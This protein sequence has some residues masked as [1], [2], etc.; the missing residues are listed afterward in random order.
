MTDNPKTLGEAL[1]KLP[2]STAPSLGQRVVLG[3]LNTVNVLL[4]TILTAIPVWWA[5]GDP[6]T[7]AVATTAI[8]VCALWVVTRLQRRKVQN[9]HPKTPQHPLLAHDQQG[10]MKDLE[11]RQKTVIFDGSNLYHFGLAE[12]MGPRV[13]GL[14]ARQLRAEGYRVVCFFDANIHFTLIENGGA[15]TGKRHSIETLQ[16]SFDIGPDEIYVVPSGVQADKFILDSLKHLPISFAVTN[17]RFRDYGKSYAAVMKGDQW[18]KGVVV[19]KNE[20]R[21]QKHRFKSPVYVN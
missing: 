12:N 11:L 5:V 3:V 20:I 13:L 10:F 21:I 14:I 6:Q 9:Q 18:R 4:L 19:V 2:S 15:P 16:R 8:V 7:E 17:D 1:N